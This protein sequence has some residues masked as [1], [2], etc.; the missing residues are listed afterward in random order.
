MPKTTEETALSIK[1]QETTELSQTSMSSQAVSEVQGALILAKRFP[2][3]E[4]VAYAKLI[5]SCQRSGFAERAG[6]EKVAFVHATILAGKRSNF[7]MNLQ[8]S[9]TF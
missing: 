9:F 8:I 3:D 2:R 5:K 6:F 7:K 1:N 4:D